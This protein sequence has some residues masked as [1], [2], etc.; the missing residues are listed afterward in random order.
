MGMAVG[1]GIIVYLL[2]LG[3][4]IERLVI[5]QVASLDELRVLD[6]AAGETTTQK[7]NTAVMAKIS[8]IPTVK[9][10]LPVVSVVGRVNYKNAKIDMLV[11]AVSQDYLKASRLN[12]LKGTFFA[13][14][15]SHTFNSERGQVA[16]A[17]TELTKARIY[18]PVTGKKTLFNIKPGESAPVWKT[19]SISSSIAGYSAH[20]EGGYEGTE[21]W[22][23]EYYPFMPYGRQGYD[24]DSTSYLGKWIMA[25][26]PLYAKDNKDVLTPVLDDMGR[27]IYDTG[28]IQ[29]KNTY[30]TDQF[31]VADVLGASTSSAQI[32][33]EKDSVVLAASDSATPTY[34]TTIVAT[35]SSGLEVVKLPSCGYNIVT[36]GLESPPVLGGVVAT[37]P[38]GRLL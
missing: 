34:D 10:V 8:K 30:I 26:V 36:C 11:Y 17:E 29:Q 23:G 22:G 38:S 4:G 5:S 1:V 12:F 15:N 31:A 14:A 9:Q 18:T 28:C 33:Y 13:S 16:G 32:E 21:M 24:T 19:C 25:K 7:I 35:D 37:A 6:V 20:L 3:Y 2:S 27:Q